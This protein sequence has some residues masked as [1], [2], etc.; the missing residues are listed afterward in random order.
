ML[1]AFVISMTIIGCFRVL[2]FEAVN[3][4]KYM[5]RIIIIISNQR[6][7]FNDIPVFCKVIPSRLVAADFHEVIDKFY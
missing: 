5:H 3:E 6:D 4:Q 1:S 2:F 7:A